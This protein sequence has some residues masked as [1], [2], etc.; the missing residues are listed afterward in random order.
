[1]KNTTIRNCI[2][3]LSACVIL[4]AGIYY[5]KTPKEQ[6]LDLNT[7]LTDLN[8][9]RQ[10]ELEEPI[11]IQVEDLEKALQPVDFTE[12]EIKELY[13][14]GVTRLLTKEEAI[15]DVK[16]FFRM[17]SQHYGGYI[18][19]GGK[20]RFD[21][22]EQ[23]AIATV[24][25]L[26]AL[27]I[28]SGILGEILRQELD[29]VVDSHF[30]INDEPLNF[31]EQYCYY[32][33]GINQIEKDTKGYYILEQGK[34]YY[35]DEAFMPYIKPTI[36]EEGQLVYGL[37]AVVE[38]EEKDKLPTS[39]SLNGVRKNDSKEVEWKLCRTGSSSLEKGCTT[40]SY[41][42]IS[43]IPIVSYT[44]M[45]INDE[46]NA[47]IEEGEKLRDKEVAVLD[48]R[49]NGGGESLINYM[50]LY[51]ITGEMI[52]PKQIEIFYKLDKGIKGASKHNSLQYLK[53]NEDPT[54]PDFNKEEIK[55]MKEKERWCT[56]YYNAGARW[57][58][59]DT[60]WFVLVDKNVGSAAEYLLR[61]LRTMSNVVIV[62]TNSQGALVTGRVI[63]YEPLY[64]PNSKIKISYGRTLMVAN[65]MEGFDVG[66]MLPDLYIA[67]EDALDA[68]IRCV[69]Y[70]KGEFL[71]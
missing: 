64:L 58:E 47:F 40:Y 61:Q 28:T 3:G 50:W 63:R 53:F 26:S 44:Q 65:E 7:M 49:G 18:Y 5:Y 30:T 13:T 60:L 42:E 8:S 21:Q 10:E 22:V 46:T 14:P 71:D 69:E 36:G 31:E 12:E 68:V 54:N 27:K 11:Q 17:I 20:E 2:I 6:S 4:G 1:M 59:N 9:K 67:D 35:I 16:V 24:E 62:G 56:T 41:K 39:I 33:S 37:F 70:Y 48:L 32:G 66:G 52:Y 34:K 29:F 38:E 57:T 15:E 55:Y 51:Q 25:N 23:R 43:Q 19:F 45:E